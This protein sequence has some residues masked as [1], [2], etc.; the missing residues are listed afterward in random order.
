MDNKQIIKISDKY[1]D[2]LQRKGAQSKFCD[3]SLNI[4]PGDPRIYDHCLFMCGSIKKFASDGESEKAIRWICFI[5]GVLWSSGL[6]S[7]DSMRE[8]NRLILGKST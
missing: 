5:Q 7:V 4:I 8:D 2:I 3:T 1:A 6:A